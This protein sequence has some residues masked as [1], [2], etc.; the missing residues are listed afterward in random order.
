MRTGAWPDSSAMA[1]YRVS[2]WWITAEWT[3]GAMDGQREC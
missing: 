3:D 2:V 1:C